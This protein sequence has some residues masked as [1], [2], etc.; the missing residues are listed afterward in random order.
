MWPDELVNWFRLTTTTKGFCI[1]DGNFH[2]ARERFGIHHTWSSHNVLVKA[3]GKRRVVGPLGE[4]PVGVIFENV[5]TDFA[6]N[7]GDD[8]DTGDF[9]ETWSAQEMGLWREWPY[10][11]GA[12]SQRRVLPQW[13]RAALLALYEATKGSLLSIL[14]CHYVNRGYFGKPTSVQERDDSTNGAD[15]DNGALRMDEHVMKVMHHSHGSEQVDVKHALYRLDVRV[16]GW[17]GVGYATL[18]S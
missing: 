14:M 10:F 3:F 8:F 6:R 16:D 9:G 17:H 2:N 15:V 18:H 5:C 12:S 4:A 7:D 11:N 1:R 13:W